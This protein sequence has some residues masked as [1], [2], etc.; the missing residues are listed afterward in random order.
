[1]PP[2]REVFLRHCQK[3]GGV[4]KFACVPA[5]SGSTP[6]AFGSTPTVEVEY[7]PFRSVA[8]PF[9]AAAEVWRVRWSVGGA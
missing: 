8:V 2:S 3:Q 9:K 1:M 6:T 5:T 7:V 4:S